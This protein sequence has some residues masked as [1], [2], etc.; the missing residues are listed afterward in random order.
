MAFAAGILSIGRNDPDTVQPA[1]CCC[2]VSTPVPVVS[3]DLSDEFDYADLGHQAAL[4]I[5][6]SDRARG[7]T[8]RDHPPASEHADPWQPG[9]AGASGARRG[10]RAG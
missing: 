6:S 4:G 3:G 2:L 1:L 8:T 10:C 9:F 5:L 7:A